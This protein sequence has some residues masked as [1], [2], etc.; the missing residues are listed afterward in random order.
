MSCR[1]MLIC[2]TQNRW[3]SI[4]YWILMSILKEVEV[5]W[6]WFTE[7]KCKTF[8][9]EWVS[10]GSWSRTYNPTT[11]NGDLWCF[12][13]F[14]PSVQESWM[15]HEFSFSFIYRSMWVNFSFRIKIS[16]SSYLNE[17][18]FFSIVY[19]QGMSFLLL[20]CVY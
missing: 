18:L 11:L 4:C 10:Q 7:L 17:W 16:G 15:L 3:L 12:N 14:V 6:I 1:I 19:M 9:M 8:T 5:L 13:L 2:F 20:I